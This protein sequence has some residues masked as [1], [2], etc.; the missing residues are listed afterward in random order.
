MTNRPI[1]FLRVCI[2]I[3]PAVTAASRFCWTTLSLAAVAS[4]AVAAS[5]LYSNSDA[6][7]QRC[8]CGG[9]HSQSHSDS[10]ACLRDTVYMSISAKFTNASF[11]NLLTENVLLQIISRAHCWHSR[12]KGNSTYARDQLWWAC[13]LVK[14]IISKTLQK[15][16]QALCTALWLHR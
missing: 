6:C 1:S 11:R 2:D 10:G 9:R 4:A 5:Q 12:R 7:L 15:F 14:L 8:R 16:L 13:V 3:Q